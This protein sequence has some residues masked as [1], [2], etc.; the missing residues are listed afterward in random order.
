MGDGLDP[1][2]SKCPLPIKL[3]TLT[4]TVIQG[5]PLSAVSSQR[6]TQVWVHLHQFLTTDVWRSK[7]SGEALQL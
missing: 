4:A 2:R 7:L 1:L 6:Q 5:A 3:G